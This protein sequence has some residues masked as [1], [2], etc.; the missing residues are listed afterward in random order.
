MG[1]YSKNE[2]NLLSLYYDAL[3]CSSIQKEVDKHKS[4]KIDIAIERI[5]AARVIIVSC[6]LHG[7]NG[8]VLY[9]LILFSDL[10]PLYFLCILL[11]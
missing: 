6:V 11:Y 5:P 10:F 8:P 7:N 9:R 4:A 3:Y 1:G 2:N